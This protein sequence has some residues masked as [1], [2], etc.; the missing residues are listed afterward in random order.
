VDNPSIAYFNSSYYLLHQKQLQPVPPPRI[1]PP[2]MKLVDVVGAAMINQIQAAKKISFHAMG[3]TGAA[4]VSAFQSAATA[5]A[6][7]GTVA[8]AMAADVQQA[9]SV[10]PQ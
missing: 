4:K 1:S 9:G 2:N 5:I 8:D 10:M 6:H 3:D 7:E